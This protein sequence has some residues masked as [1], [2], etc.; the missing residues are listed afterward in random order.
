MAYNI[1]TTG[2]GAVVGYGVIRSIRNSKKLKRSR[3]IGIDN[4]PHAVGFFKCDGHYTISRVSSPDYIDSLIDICKKEAVD[5][6]IPN[7]EDEL[8]PIH[9]HMRRFTEAGIKVVIQP[10]QVIEVYGDKYL[11]SIH[12]KKLG[13]AT[14]DTCLFTPSNGEKIAE[15]VNSFGLPLILKPRYGRSS[16]GILLAETTKQL[17]AYMDALEGREYIVQEY[18]GGGDREYT[19][20]VFKVPSMVEPYTILLKRQLSNGMTISA[21]VV[22]DDTLTDLCRDIADKVP[23]EGSLNVQAMV[24]DGVPYVFEINTRY[25]S[26]TYMR[27]KCGFNDVQMGID[28]FLHGRIDRPPRIKEYR[29]ARFW[30]EIFISGN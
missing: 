19:C 18:L 11:T 16:K 30:E 15:M 24:R 26:T 2:V 17:N 28:Y 4:N 6:L 14:P 25:S 12:L 8:L 13:I 23:I 22:H 9:D 21:E 3:I 20:A 1:A 5:V 7:I 10:R 27:A 29:I